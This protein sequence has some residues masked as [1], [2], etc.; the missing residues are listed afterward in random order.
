MDSTYRFRARSRTFQ[1]PLDRIRQTNPPGRAVVFLLNL[2]HDE[3]RGK[4]RKRR[5]SQEIHAKKLTL[6]T[7]MT[8][9]ER[10]KKLLGGVLAAWRT[11]TA[12]MTVT[13][14]A[15]SNRLY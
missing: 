11:Y 9:S 4:V 3:R 7:A 6:P 2:S 15:I 14:A 5:S 8:D 13:L 1:R 12:L 10:L